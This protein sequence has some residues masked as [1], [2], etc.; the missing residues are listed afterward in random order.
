MNQ[1]QLSAWRYRQIRMVAPPGPRT[2]PAFTVDKVRGLLARA[3]KL[4]RRPRCVDGISNEAAIRIIREVLRGQPGKAIVSR[5]TWLAAC[6][7]ADQCGGVA[8]R[9]SMRFPDCEEA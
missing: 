4:G 9:G 5:Y 3:A 6:Y 7:L 8:G 2:S 1:H